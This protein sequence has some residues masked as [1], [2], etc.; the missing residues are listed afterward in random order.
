[1]YF[2]VAISKYIQGTKVLAWLSFC[3]WTSPLSTELRVRCIEL[4]SYT[5]GG[6]LEDKNHHDRG[7]S[8]TVR[9]SAGQSIVEACGERC[10]TTANCAY[11]FVYTSG[12]SKGH[13]FPKASVDGS[14][15]SAAACTPSKGGCES[16]FFQVRN[17][18][19]RPSPPECCEAV[20]WNPPT[21]PCCR[22]RCSASQRSRHH[23]RQA[24]APCSAIG[25]T[26]RR[27]R[28]A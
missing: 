13:C 26:L 27:L 18:Q 5:R 25:P 12:R 22:I 21:H 15:S 1:M 8:I 14:K 23:H 24:R 4:H 9:P 28:S 20:E 2:T 11:F 3:R 17:W 10:R 19:P 6:G 16:A 7:S